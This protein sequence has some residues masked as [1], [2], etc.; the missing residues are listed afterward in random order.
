MCGSGKDTVQDAPTLRGCRLVVKRTRLIRPRI[1]SHSN[2]LYSLL[3]PLPRRQ[4][5]AADDYY[6]AEKLEDES[7][8][9]PGG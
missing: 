5:V 2:L 6:H 1:R 3:A 9:R 4:A 7:G 8:D